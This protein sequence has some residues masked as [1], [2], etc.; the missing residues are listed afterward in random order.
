VEG[1]AA[2]DVLAIIA[3]L[4]GTLSRDIPAMLAAVRTPVLV[5][6]APAPASLEGP[7]SALRG[8]ARDAIRALVPPDRFVILDGG[9]CLHRDLPDQ[10]VA[11]VA[12]YADA[13]VG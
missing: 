4:D 2:A 11:A 6:A 13:V 8:P 3:G 10:W 12:A 7:G 5:L 9:H 1:I